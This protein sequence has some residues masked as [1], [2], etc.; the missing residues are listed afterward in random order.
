MRNLVPTAGLLAVV[1]A[2]K[3]PGSYGSIHNGL[4]PL[5][6]ELRQDSHRCSNRL[7]QD[8]GDVA[9]SYVYNERDQL[10]SETDPSSSTSYGYDAAGWMVSKANVSG[11]TTYGWQDNDRMVTVNG[12]GVSVA[13]VYDHEGR[14][15]HEITAGGTKRYLIDGLLPYGQVVAET[16]GSGNLVAAYVYGLERIA[17]ER[18]G[19]TC[20]YAADGQGSV[21]QLTDASGAVTDAYWYTAFGEELATTGT[22]AN[23]FRYSGE[24]WDPNAGFYYLRARWM[25]PSTGRFTS[26]DPAVGDRLAPVSLHRYL[27]SNNSP[28]TFVDPTGNFTLVEAMVV[29]ADLTILA[30]YVI[31]APH[32]QPN[33]VYVDFGGLDAR[34]AQPT[35]KRIEADFGPWNIQIDDK[36]PQ[37][38]YTKI[39]FENCDNSEIARILSAEV[40]KVKNGASGF[41]LPYLM[42]AF[43]AV[44]AYATAMR[45]SFGASWTV[46][47]GS[48]AEQ[49]YANMLANFASHEIGHFYRTHHHHNHGFIMYTAEGETNSQE[50]SSDYSDNY[51]TTDNQRQLDR[52]IGRK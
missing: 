38:P 51:W 30:S 42:P 16:D 27:Y 31:L 15:V 46:T 20:T 35:L 2:F 50:S 8:R 22:T 40:Y 49:I 17:Q 9:T 18:A 44:D 36:P 13:Y 41:A 14:R 5:T 29:V 48:T 21:R 23:G 26:V 24:Q 10:A 33:K 12:P 43:G 6:A 11:T 52:Y 47:D 45:A 39:K 37:W 4:S 1:L 7:T 3:S 34:Y 25:S 19:V 28:A 32:I